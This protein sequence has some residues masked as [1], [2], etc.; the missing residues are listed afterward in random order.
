MKW[1]L[2]FGALAHATAVAGQAA[3]PAPDTLRPRLLDPV[4]VT[5]ART[6]SPLSTSAFAVTRIGAARLAGIPHATM[7]DLLRAVPG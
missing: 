5:A 6:G 7:A 3:P 2:L 4:V 1:R